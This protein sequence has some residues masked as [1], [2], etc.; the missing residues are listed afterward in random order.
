MLSSGKSGWVMA[1]HSLRD[2]TAALMLAAS[3][4]FGFVVF[5]P[6]EPAF[7]QFRGGKLSNIRVLVDSFDLVEQAL[8]RPLH[9]P[10]MTA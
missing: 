2:Q 9:L 4:A 5:A 1:F 7:A 10:R 3:V 6:T 8:G